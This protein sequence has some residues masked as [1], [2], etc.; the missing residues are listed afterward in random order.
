M[1]EGRVTH[2]S[3][4]LFAPDAGNA[5]KNIARVIAKDFGDGEKSWR[6]F[7]D[8]KKKTCLVIGRLNRRL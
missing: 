4:T 5:G 7:S 2:F 1:P 6:L 8:G 3:L